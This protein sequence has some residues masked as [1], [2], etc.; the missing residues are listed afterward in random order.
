MFTS[1][2]DR[3]H[4]YRQAPRPQTRSCPGTPQ[5][6]QGRVCPNDCCEGSQP[7]RGFV[8]MF[9]LS[10]PREQWDQWEHRADGC[11][12]HAG[13]F[14]RDQSDHAANALARADLP[15]SCCRCVKM[16]SRHR[17]ATVLP[18]LLPLLAPLRPRFAAAEARPDQHCVGRQE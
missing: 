13:G 18:L 17:C 6:G 7:R 14:S 5:R 9:N 2:I 16:R 3:F 15:H 11:E 4:H 8:F 12:R 1:L 10:A